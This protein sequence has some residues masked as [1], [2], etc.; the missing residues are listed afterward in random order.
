MYKRQ[1]VLEGVPGARLTG[2]PARRLPCHA[3]FVVPGIGGEPLL[4]ALD[5]RG[6]LASSGSACAAGR[7]E[8]SAVL[9]AMGVDAD[10]ARTAVRF[11]WGA[12]TTPEELARAAEEL[13]QSAATLRGLG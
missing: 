11:T 13:R 3:S 10:T 2:H 4:V 12:S 5:D 1:A 7:D 6:I 9:V 8:P